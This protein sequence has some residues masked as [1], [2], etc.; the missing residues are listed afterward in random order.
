MALGFS[1]Q[2]RICSS[3]AI[4]C[5][6]GGLGGILIDLLVRAGVGHLRVV[7]GDVFVP[8]NLN[9][10]RLCDTE[11]ISRPKAKVAEERVGAI[12]P[13]VEIEFHSERLDAGNV[14]ELVR[15]MDLILDG[16]DNLETRFLLAGAA[17]RLKIAFIHAAVA[18]WW[19]QITTFLPESSFDLERIYGDKRAR[20]PT[21]NW[22][23]VLGTT[24]AVVA[25]LQAFEAIRLLSGRRPAYADRLLYFDGESGQMEILPL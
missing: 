20:D 17:R 12:N 15:G 19:G 5:G 4:V 24:A 13:L 7:D 1:E 6:C 16:L 21:E 2:I 22:L 3:K 23:G 10:Q 11:Q 18:G 25:S 14:H 9:R 8:S